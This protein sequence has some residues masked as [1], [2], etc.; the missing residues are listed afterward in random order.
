M[1]VDNIQLWAD[2]LEVVRLPEITSDVSEL[3]SLSASTAAELSA[4]SQEFADTF[5]EHSIRI[6]VADTAADEAQ[7]DATDAL[8]SLYQNELSSRAYVDA[9]IQRLSQSTADNLIAAINILTSTITAST[10]TRIDATVPGFTNEL[11]AIKSEI[12]ADVALG[13]Q[14]SVALQLASMD[15]LNNTVPLL[16]SLQDE[17]LVSIEGQQTRIDNLLSQYEHTTL[18]QGFDATLLESGALLEEAV[19]STLLEA[20]NHASNAQ[21]SSEDSA[22]A[23]E[24]SESSAS[25]AE[26][27]QA[28]SSQVY[29][30]NL[31]AARRGTMTGLGT[32]YQSGNGQFQEGWTGWITLEGLSLD[33][34][35]SSG[36]EVGILFGDDSDTIASIDIDLG[37]TQILRAGDAT[38]TGA[39]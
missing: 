39:E 30:H 7:I 5:S 20:E 17:A 9:A 16:T 18:N 24:S 21:V 37:L 32:V 31:T 6:T 4:K 36:I 13:N 34:S 22:R 33:F 8:T 19:E 38:I 12:N 28:V 1:P 23:A 15:L 2:N 26:S 27:V 10:T 14:T 11:N 3:Q 25:K 35:G 29:D